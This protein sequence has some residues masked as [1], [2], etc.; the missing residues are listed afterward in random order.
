MKNNMTV[1]NR[2]NVLAYITG[3]YP[4]ATDTFIQREVA[5]LRQLGWRVLPYAVR[6]PGSEH[7]V[8]TAVAAEQKVTNYLLPF[9]WIAL[10]AV[11]LGFLTS[12]P[13]N[14][15]QTLKL[16]VRTRKPGF[17]GFAY[18]MAYFLEATWLAHDLVKQGATHLHNHLGDASATVAMLAARL[19]GIGFSMTIHGPHIFFD[20]VNWALRQ[21]VSQANFVICIS[22]FCT[23]QMMLF[24]DRSDWHK[25]KLVHCGVDT[26]TYPWCRPKD[27]GNS[28]L[29]VGRLAA[30]KGIL[31]LLDSFA[32]LIKN[33]PQARLRLAGDGE[34]RQVL[35]TRVAEMGLGDH[36]LF[37][38]YCSQEAV[39]QQLEASDLF[40]LPS[41]AEGVPVSLMEAMAIGVPVVSTFVG[42][43][44]EL[45]V[46]EHTG[47]MVAAGN[48]QQLAHAMRRGLTDGPLRQR[49]SRAAREKVEQ[50]YDLVTQVAKLSE[51]FHEHHGL[52]RT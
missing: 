15:Y 36:V 26:P 21:K 8:S 16:A 39:R 6:R 33:R 31:V 23:S 29:Y 3:C 19:A 22:N 44:V 34:D 25:F 35:Q 1:P 30:E 24:S 14:Y 20:P 9:R 40:V 4:R 28:I 43:V 45:V 17:R 7:A 27:H 11:N 46:P 49:L 50:D 48:A 12:Q 42:G 10:V 5:C 47:L 32:E 52:V 13:A 2:G 37:L 18:Q 38:G 51:L 41:F